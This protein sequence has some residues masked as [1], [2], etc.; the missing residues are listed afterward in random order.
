MRRIF[1]GVVKLRATGA[2]IAALEQG[3][4]SFILYRDEWLI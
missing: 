4:L 2:A 1:T 3:T